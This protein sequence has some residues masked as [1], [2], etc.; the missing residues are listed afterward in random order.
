M[1]Q[2]E[3]QALERVELMKGQQKLDLVSRRQEASEESHLFTFS[4]QYCEVKA[5]E[6]IYFKVKMYLEAQA[7]KEE[8]ENLEKAEQE[9]HAGAV[10]KK[11]DA[12]VEKLEKKQK[13]V[14][15]NVMKRIRRDRDEQLIKRKRE[16][17][18]L[19]K[20]NRNEIGDLLEQ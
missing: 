12:E 10:Q 5:Q 8:A 16:A 20:R 19:V 14:L 18:Q 3:D 17:D 7:C 13:F 6:A 15:E 1:K 4:K 11:L 9:A 2:E